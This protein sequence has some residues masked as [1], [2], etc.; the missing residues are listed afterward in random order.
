MEIPAAMRARDP[1]AAAHSST[2]I[3]SVS[4]AVVAG[5]AVL[6]QRDAGPAVLAAHGG[7]DRAGGRRLRLPADHG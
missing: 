7:R 2:L 3:L 1:A 6:T 5:F 4:A